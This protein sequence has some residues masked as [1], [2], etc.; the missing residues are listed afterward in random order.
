VKEVIGLNHG[1]TR[2]WLHCLE[3]DDEENCCVLWPKFKNKFNILVAERFFSW[4]IKG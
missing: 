4:P 2:W 1:G 3:I